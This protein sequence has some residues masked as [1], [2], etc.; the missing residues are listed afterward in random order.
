MLLHKSVEFDSRVRREASALAGAG[1]EVTVLELAPVPSEAHTMDGFAR[2]SVLPPAWLRRRLPFHLYRAAFL[3]SFVMGVRRVRPDTVHAHDAAMLLPGVIGARLTGA[4]LVYDSHELATSVPYRE[5][6]W[7]AFVAGIERLVI[8]RCAA[9]ITVSDGIAQRLRERY[10]LPVTPCVVRNVS[11]LARDGHP[12][13]RKRLGIAPDTPLVLHQGAPAPARGCEVLIEAMIDLPGVHL[14]FLGDPEPGYGAALASLVAARGLK[15][16]ITLLESVALEDLLAHTAEADVGVTLL[17]DTCLNHRLALPNKLFEYIAAGIPVV[18]AALPET[19]R[20]VEDYGVGWC[21]RPDDPA[22]VAGALRVALHGPRDPGLR[23]RLE[24]AADALSWQREQLPLL[25]LYEW[26]S[27]VGAHQHKA[28]GAQNRHPH[29]RPVQTSGAPGQER[30]QGDRT[31]SQL[32]AQPLAQ[33]AQPNQARVG[34]GAPHA[35]LPDR[36]FAAG[37][38]HAPHFPQRP[39]DLLAPAHGG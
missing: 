31:Y 24:R 37:S 39:P 1:H 4:R 33:L 32:P 30:Q 6:A 17:Q 10:R 13:L 36:D 23:E 22:A 12:G 11:A 9:V 20:L 21:A 3:W 26:S 16:R 25:E 14:A 27:A 38:E 19:Q 8:P 5:R 7:A 15:E 34:V 18:A 35:G 29:E 28:M 2:R